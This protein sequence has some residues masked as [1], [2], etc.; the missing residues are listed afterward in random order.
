MNRYL[1]QIKAIITTFAKVERGILKSSPQQVY[2]P[3]TS[4]SCLPRVY[5]M[6]SQ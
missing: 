5:P 1:A 4:L 6:D 2:P 3:N